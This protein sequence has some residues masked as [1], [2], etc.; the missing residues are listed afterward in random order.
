MVKPLRSDAGRGAAEIFEI[1]GAADETVAAAATT[2]EFPPMSTP[3]AGKGLGVGLAGP[4]VIRKPL[5]S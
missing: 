5:S 2:G 4:V 1:L 3:D